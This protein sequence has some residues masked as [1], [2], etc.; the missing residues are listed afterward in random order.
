[1]PLNNT[2]NESSLDEIGK[3]LQSISEKELQ[4]ISFAEQAN[5]L[6]ESNIVAFSNFFPEIA[7]KF[8]NHRPSSNF[9]LF[10]NENGTANLV[11]YDTGVPIYSNDPVQ[12]SRRQLEKMLN[13][14]I[15]GR[16]DH[17]KLELISNE[18]NFVHIDLMKSIGGVYNDAARALE[19][20]TKVDKSIPSAIIFGVGLGYY[21]ENFFD[22]FNASYISIFEPNEDYFFASLLK[23]SGLPI[24]LVWHDHYG[25]SELLKIRK[26]R[27]LKLLST[28]F[29]GIISV[30]K[31]LKDWAIENLMTKNVV[32][33]NNFVPDS[34]LT[35]FKQKLKGPE[36]S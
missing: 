20:N 34:Q 23:L 29:D 9:N 19:S 7:N 14:P 31:K 36:E 33:I 15:I 12:Q 18:T 35:N 22:T 24:K 5:T 30:N 8:S 27:I 25:E 28:S 16:V 17:S 13:N 32:M 21:L 11:D 1:M 6:F 2:D 10:L 26:S 3:K 4:E